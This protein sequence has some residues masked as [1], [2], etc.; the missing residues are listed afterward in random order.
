[1]KIY[2]SINEFNRAKENLS[3]LSYIPT[4]G[5]LHN[6]HAALIDKGKKLNTEVISSI[7]INKLQ[8]ND[9]NDFKNY[10][11]TLVN[12][13]NLL[14]R[15][16]CDHLLIPDDSILNNI[17]SIKAPPKANKLCGLN[18]PGHFDGVLTILNKLFNII[19]P[20]NVIFG[21]KDYQQFILVKDFIKDNGL[22]IKIFG[23]E[24][25]RESN[26]LA[27]SSRNSLIS[28][29][30]KPIAPMLFKVLK[31]IDSDKSYISKDL[32]QF[33]ADY[34]KHIGFDVDYLVASD[35]ES[36]EESY[37][38]NDKDILVA[39]AA[40][41]GDVRLIDNIILTKL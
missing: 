37:S 36:L 13:I 22:D 41:L 10:P 23:L 30:Y 3:N 16:G 6:G 24:T 40:K 26:G 39:L 35:S 12:D 4:M 1:M 5:N 33:K 31:E 34:L 8:F 19:K 29:E 15:H 32:L 21:K 27:L 28:T 17:Q 11:K 7:Y 25:I 20:S 14:K 9:N 18:R 38:I 2:N